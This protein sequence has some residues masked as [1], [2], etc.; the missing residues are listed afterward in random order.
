MI[1]FMAFNGG[2]HIEN[3]V[4]KDGLGVASS[5]MNTMLGGAAGGITAMAVNKCK[6]RHIMIETGPQGQATHWSCIMT[7]NGGLAGIFKK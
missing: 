3:V 4:G 2:S 7:I 5:I 1:G 6:R